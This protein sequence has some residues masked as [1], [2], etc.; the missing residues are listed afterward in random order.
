MTCNRERRDTYRSAETQQAAWLRA[1]VP[2][3]GKAAPRVIATLGAYAAHPTSKGTNGGVAHPDWAGHLRARSRGPLR[4]GRAALHD[5]SRQHVAGRRHRTRP[6]CAHAAGRRRCACGPARCVRRARDVAPARH[7]RAPRR[8]RSARVLRSPLQPGSRGRCRPPSPPTAPCVSASVVSLEATASVLRL[9]DDLAITTG[10]GELFSNLT[11]T[12]IERSPARVTM[13]LS[14][15][16]DALGYIP[17]SFE[18]SPIGQQGLGFVVRR[19]P[20]RELRGLLRHRPL[21]RG[22]DPREDAAAARRLTGDRNRGAAARVE[23]S[24]AAHLVLRLH[25][26]GVPCPPMPGTPS[27][28]DSTTPPSWPTS[29][30]TSTGSCAPPSGSSRW[31]C[32]CGWTTAASRCSPAGGCTTTPPEGPGKGGIRFH[33]DVDVDEVK[34]LAAAMTFKTAVLDLP[35]GGAKGGVRCDPD[36]AVARRARAPDP[37]LHLRDQPAARARPRRARPRHQH[38]RPGH[39]LAHGHALDDPGHPPA[40]VG[41]RQAAGGRRHPRPRGGHVVRVPRVRPRRVR[42]AGHAAWPAAAP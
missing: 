26:G 18:M 41:D 10:P 19:L 31:R 21:L 22:R 16:N 37:P 3:T 30:R 25:L 34:A 39:G 11:N 14:Q 4:R 7:Q 28:S 8:A 36:R 12:I 15:A 27:S 24:R 23:R 1:Y 42:R 20:D 9:G 6:G 40:G 33:P 2:G 29:T 17:Q 32:P 35:F 38:R 13:P 5:R